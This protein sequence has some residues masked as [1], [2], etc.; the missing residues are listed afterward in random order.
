MMMYG[1]SC[2]SVLISWRRQGTAMSWQ[3]SSQITRCE[4]QVLEA[5][6]I[7]TR[8]ACTRSEFIYNE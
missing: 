8:N 6:F 1:H 5:S 2:S 7:L 4:R 3:Q